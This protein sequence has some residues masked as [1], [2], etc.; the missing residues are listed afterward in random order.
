MRKTWL[1]RANTLILAL[2]LA[3]GGAG[4]P[5]ADAIFHHLNGSSSNGDRVSDGESAGHAE[6]CTLGVPMPAMATAGAVAVLPSR[7]SVSF[8]PIAIGGEEPPR[9]ASTAGAIRPRAPPTTNG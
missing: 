6:R 8:L 9:P 4:L 3:G 2:L 1:T 5:V 7:T